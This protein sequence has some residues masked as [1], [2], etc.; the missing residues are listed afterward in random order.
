MPCA[1]KLSSVAVQSLS[2]CFKKL[3]SLLFL[4]LLA[5]VEEDKLPKEF[6]ISQ[7]VTSKT[8]KIKAGTL[9]KVVEGMLTSLTTNAFYDVNIFLAGY[10]AFASTKEVLDLLL[11]R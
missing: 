10:R 3:T 8:R 4:L 6:T 7:C 2:S 11:D 5:Q 1:L 9:E